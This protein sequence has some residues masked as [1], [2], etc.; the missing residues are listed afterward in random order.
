MENTSMDFRKVTWECENIVV[1]MIFYDNY[2]LLKNRFSHAHKEVA[3]L[4]QAI[5]EYEIF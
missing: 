1:I 4:F 2:N 3:K 5:Y